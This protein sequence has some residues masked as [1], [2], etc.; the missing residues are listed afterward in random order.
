M[1]GVP[2]MNPFGFNVHLRYM[3][4]YGKFMQRMT[5]LQPAVLTVMV[6]DQEPGKEDQTVYIKALADA[7]PKTLIV[8]RVKHRM[9]GGY[10][11]KPRTVPDYWVAS[12]TNFLNKWGHLG[13]DNMTLYAL[14][15]PSGKVNDAETID[16]LVR[17]CVEVMGEAAKRG[18]SLTLPNFGTGLPDLGLTGQWDYTFDP[19]LKSLSQY[20]Q[21]HY[22][23]LHEYLPGEPYRV[24]RLMFMMGRCQTLNIEPPKIIITEFGVDD[25]GS[26]DKRNGYKSRGWSGDFYMRTLA[27]TYKRTYSSF[28]GSGKIVGTCLFSYGNSG[29]WDS[30]D[31]ENDQSF[32]DTLQTLVNSGGLTP[33]KPIPVQPPETPK[34]EPA[35]P[36]EPPAPVELPPPAKP[37]PERKP[38]T[39]TITI[40]AT[41][42]EAAQVTALGTLILDSLTKLAEA[43]ASAKDLISR[44]VIQDMS[45]E[46]QTQ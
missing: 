9:D 32:F 38:R 45:K 12:P 7:L 2:Q 13:R 6:D 39:W 20:R 31:V 29:G 33:T 37:E 16:R 41:D 34:P 22:I 24:G 8:A 19:I 15:E 18:I 17:W 44:L 46:A 36:T 4:D 30:F 27:D 5:A 26:G 23:G 28:V 14:N 3:K 42:E 43:T 40:M 35:K 1:E 25:D 21:L 10:H 11:T